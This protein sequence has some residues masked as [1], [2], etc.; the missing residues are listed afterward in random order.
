MGAILEQDFSNMSEVTVGL[1]SR[2]FD[3]YHLNRAQ[4]MTIWNYHRAIDEFL[5]GGGPR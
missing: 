3:G 4:E 2:G 5:F 1:H